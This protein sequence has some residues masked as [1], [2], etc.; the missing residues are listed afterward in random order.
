MHAVAARIE[1]VLLHQ[2]PADVLRQ[3]GQRWYSSGPARFE[4][5]APPVVP[6]ALEQLALHLLGQGRVEVRVRLVPD[7][8]RQRPQR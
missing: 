8:P 6:A 2:A 7:Q 4:E 1:Q 3:V 5:E